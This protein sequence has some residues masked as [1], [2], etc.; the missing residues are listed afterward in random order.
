MPEAAIGHFPDVGASR[1]LSRLRGY[2]G[3]YI[4]IYVYVIVYSWFMILT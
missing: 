3:N 1:F 2:F 4:Y